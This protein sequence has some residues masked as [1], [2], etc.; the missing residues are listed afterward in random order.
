MM[1]K[2]F[3]K[4]LGISIVGALMI[5]GLVL[6]L[7]TPFD[8]FLTHDDTK[9]SKNDQIVYLKKHEK[10]MTEGVMGW[11]YKIKSVEWEW[12]TIEVGQ[13]GN[14]TPQGGG[15]LLTIGGSFNEIKKSTFTIGFDLKDGNSYPSIN[16]FYQMQPFRVE[17]DLYE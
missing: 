9:V 4:I 7:G 15:W 8:H 5:G 13:I 3:K 2:R 11:N 17:G 14:G 6:A 10:E 12:D 16:N 1:T